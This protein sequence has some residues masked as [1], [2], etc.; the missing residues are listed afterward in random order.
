MVDIVDHEVADANQVK[1]L[2]L[3]PN[4]GDH[5]IYNLINDTHLLLTV[6]E[7]ALAVGV[8]LLV[9]TSFSLV[10]LRMVLLFL[11]SVAVIARC[12][13][14]AAFLVLADKGSCLPVLT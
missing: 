6:V 10:V 5:D 14:H 11:P 7:R 3:I 4:S 8:T 13:K 1:L 2:T 12:L 9:I